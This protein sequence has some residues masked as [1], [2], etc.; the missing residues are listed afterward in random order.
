MFISKAAHERE[1]RALQEELQ[2]SRDENDALKAQLDRLQRELDEAR[3]SSVREDEL[4]GLMTFENENMK[5]G[6]VDI[7]ANIASS[8]NSAKHTLSMVSEINDDFDRIAG[9]INTIASTLNG[10]AGVAQQSNGVVSN[11]SEHAGKISSVL[12]LI[13]GISEQTNLLALN[14]AIEAARAGE[15]GRGFAVVADEVRN[16]A[17]KTR[18]AINDT[19]DVI[20]SMLGNV[21]DVE[22][23]SVQLVDGV[24]HIDESV[25][26][27]KERLNHIYSGVKSSFSDVSVMADSVFMSLAKLDHIIWKVN[28][29]LS[30]NKREPAFQFVD[31]HNCRLGKW[32]Y[33]GDGK[34]FFSR[35]RFYTALE[36]PHAGVHNGTHEVFD[37]ISRQPL[38]YNALLQVLREMEQSSSGVF[39]GLDDIRS[40]VHAMGSN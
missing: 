26:G 6:L 23:S 8:V 18:S 38:D 11:L 22:Q 28:T 2:R 33:E 19:R 3:S 40:D 39:S 7:Q 12:T 14:A 16:L 15:A 4:N 1:V 21:S 9:E 27:F 17:D 30:I 31:H 20:E 5:T 34:Q 32:Y 35:S 36:R 10:L 24:S 37:I 13:Q 25:T 29:Y